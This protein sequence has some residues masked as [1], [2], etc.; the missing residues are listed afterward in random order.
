MTA[1]DELRTLMVAKFLPWPVNSGDKRRTLGIARALRTLGPVT[2]CAFAT[3]D[4]DSAPLEQE[5][6]TVRP[7]PL[8]R[9]P[10]S[11]VEG[12]IRTRSITAARFWS[13][14]LARTVREEVAAG[15]DVLAVEHVQLAHY[16]RRMH[17]QVRLLDMHNVES[18]L[19]VR[20]AAARG[21][22]VGAVLRAEAAALRRL[23]RSTAAF[24]HVLVVSNIDDR[25]LRRHA[26]PHSTVVVPNAWDEPTPLPPATEPVVSFVALMSWRPNVDAA[27]WFV[28]QVWPRVLDRV[29][30]A[31]LQL[32]GRNPAPAVQRLAGPSVDVTGTV[33]ELTPYYRCTAV[34]IAPLLAGGGS[35]LKILEAL[36]HARPVVATTV[37]A[38]GLEDLIGRGVEVTDDPAAMAAAIGDLLRDRDEIA[39]R[40]AAGAEAVGANHSWQAATAPLL[41]SIQ[42]QFDEVST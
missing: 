39:R 33:P 9:H 11:L 27:V 2:I 1:P 41:R 19:I 16:G 22:V 40:G 15:C 30:D 4:E 10:R 6:I 8:D 34:A 7:V 38:E 28:K 24:D 37:G 36:A 31:R 5:G 17:V 14:R 23:E 21:P 12:L 29:P 35:R 3:D 26:T 42:H 20:H 25:T 13:P 18:D 32:V